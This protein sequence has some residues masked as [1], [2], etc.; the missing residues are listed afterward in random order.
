[1]IVGQAYTVE[2]T[3]R[4]TGAM[5]WAAEGPEAVRLGYHWFNERGEELTL[6]APVFTELGHSVDQGDKIVVTARV[7]APSEPGQYTLKWDLR[8]GERGWFSELGGATLNVPVEVEIMYGAEYLSHDTPPEMVAG[9]RYRVNVRV[10]NT[11]TIPWE[12]GGPIP[13]TLSYRWLDEG[14]TVAEVERLKA[15]LPHD[16]PPGETVD[17]PAF[18]R[19]PSQPGKYSLEWDLYLGEAFW[20]SEKGVPPLRV[21]VTVK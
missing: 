2:M 12:A 15:R 20:F 19:A 13:I 11:G 7:L 6:A 18:V 5:T 8:Q 10:K 4:N 3:L 16:V 9:Q 21:R 14:G 17:I 1:M